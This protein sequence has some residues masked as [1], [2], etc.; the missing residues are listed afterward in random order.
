M[1]TF[2]AGGPEAGGWRP[3]DSRKAC[4]AVALAATA[5]TGR[6]EALAG[7]SLAG[8]RT[9]RY[10]LAGLVAERGLQMKALVV[11]LGNRPGEVARLREA[12][13]DSGGSRLLCVTA[14]GDSG[15]H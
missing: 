3:P 6:P 2:S 7:W 8:Y 14:H 9:G 15:G 13:A 12:M 4:Q 11:E 10:L 1:Q 5:P